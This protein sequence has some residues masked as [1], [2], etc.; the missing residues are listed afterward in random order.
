MSDYK[1]LGWEQLV[2][3][4]H[5]RAARVRRIQ[6]VLVG[7]GIFLILLGWWT[8]SS[9]ET[10]ATENNRASTLQGEVERQQREA[11]LALAGLP[12]PSVAREDLSQIPTTDQATEIERQMLDSLNASNEVPA[13]L[14]N[15]LDVQSLDTEAFWNDAWEAGTAYVVDTRRVKLLGVILNGGSA[16]YPQLQRWLA[17]FRHADGD[18][19]VVYISAPDFIGPPDTP[20]VDI[21]EIPITLRPVLG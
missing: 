11:R 9:I 20:S 12:A 5:V 8:F 2:T 13:S 14:P 16:E 6:P 18:W 10:S 21:G 1:P 3:D 19:E 15:G 7:L 4:G 17:V